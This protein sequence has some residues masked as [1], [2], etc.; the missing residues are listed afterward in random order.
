M[1][2]TV[3]AVG[4]IVILGLSVASWLLAIVLSAKTMRILASKHSRT[5]E[6][7]DSPRI[8]GNIGTPNEKYI[9]YIKEKRYLELNDVEINMIVLR[10]QIVNK[11]SLLLFVAT[12]LWFFVI[13]FWR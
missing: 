12:F 11:L 8:I 2:S 7:L 10:M 1:I 3:L 4:F 5:F 6:Q 13:I 9:S